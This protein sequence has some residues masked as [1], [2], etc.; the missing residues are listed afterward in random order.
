MSTNLQL[1]EIL[2]TGLPTSGKSTLLKTISSR[3][4]EAEG[5]SFGDVAVDDMLRLKFMEPPRLEQVDFMWLREMVSEIDA[6][7]FIVVCDATQ[8]E[9]FGA[10]LA[11]LESIHYSN[12]ESPCMLLANRHDSPDAWGV[13]DIKMG[14]G[15]PDF[16]DVLPCDVRN[17]AAVKDAVLR[18]L[19]KIMG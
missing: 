16:I 13:D 15:I 11:L 12:P 2:I 3:T 4:M 8:P 9:Y 19:Y 6:A 10:V 14:L 1:L 18:L 5:W 17:L 7:G